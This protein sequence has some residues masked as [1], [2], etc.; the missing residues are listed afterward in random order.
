MTK[1]LFLLGFFLFSIGFLSTP[2]VAAEVYQGLV[3]DSRNDHPVNCVNRIGVRKRL[4]SLIAAKEDREKADVPAYCQRGGFERFILFE[5]VERISNFRFIRSSISPKFEGD[6]W[7]EAYIEIRADV[8]IMPCSNVQDKQWSEECTS[9]LALYN[10]HIF[11]SDPLSTEE[12]H[13]RRAPRI[14]DLTH[15]E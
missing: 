2:V 7:R 11:D 4:N 14:I 3:Y 10:K 1:Y 15:K 9:N 8:Q 5:E 6:D 12:G 13:R